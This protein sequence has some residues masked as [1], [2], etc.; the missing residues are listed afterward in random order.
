MVLI[1]AG[2][3]TNLSHIVYGDTE[4]A[5][6]RN[7]S[8]QAISGPDQRQINVWMIAAGCSPA[9][10]WDNVRFKT[11]A[12]AYIPASV[13][14]PKGLYQFINS[15][16][17]EAGFYAPSAETPKDFKVAV[18]VDQ[19]G[20]R[21]DK[22]L[23]FVASGSTQTTTNPFP[24]VLRIT[25]NNLSTDT[26]TYQRYTVFVPLDGFLDEKAPSVLDTGSVMYSLSYFE[27]DAGQAVYRTAKVKST[28]AQT[29]AGTRNGMNVGF[30]DGSWAGQSGEKKALRT[31]SKSQLVAITNSAPGVHSLPSVAHEGQRVEL[32]N[33]ITIHGGAV[34]TAQ[35]SAG[36]SS[37]GVNISG[38]FTGYEIDSSYDN[39]S[40]G[41]DLGS[42]NP[43]NANFQG[44]VSFS[45]AHAAGNQANKTMFIRATGSYTPVAIWINGKRYAVG[46]LTDRHFY[47]LT[48]LDGTFLKAGK[49]YYV[50]AESATG[51]LYGDVTYNAGDILSYTGTHWIKEQAGLNQAQVDSRINSKVPKQFRSDAETAGQLFQ[52]K[53]FWFG[54]ATQLAAVTKEADCLYF[55]EAESQ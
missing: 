28:E 4:C 54:S 14:V 15:D 24:G 48:G 13:T 38:L 55:T 10:D 3:L 46:S 29:S 19:P 5:L 2:Q 40:T 45:N 27:T 42:L 25:Y 8:P 22:N 23:P 34:L 43:A 6:V 9:G 49:K 50:N 44:L 31:Y 51:R 30:L 39:G 18:E 37:Q 53:C 17:A 47:P 11:S 21:Q 16:W 36:T 20:A 35:E 32:L 26:D 52:P 12:N 7:T 33:D 1:K 41:G